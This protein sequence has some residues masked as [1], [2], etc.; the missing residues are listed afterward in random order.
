MIFYGVLFMREIHT[1]LITDTVCSLLLDAAYDIGRDV[2]FALDR[3]ASVEISPIGADVLSQLLENYAI[4]SSERIAV[5]QDTGMAVLFF[6]IGREVVICGG[7]FEDA[8]NEGVRRAY[9]NGHLRKS[10][11]SDPLF[12]RKNTLDNTPAVIHTRI[13]AGDHM[14]I[15]A[16]PKGFGSE[17]MSA[18][19]MLVPADGPE[20]V[21]RFIVDTVKKAGP[22][23]CPP[24]VVG[25]GIG[26][27]MEYAAIMAKKATARMIGLHN[28][29][30]R[31]ASL[32][33]E[34]LDEI[35]SLGIGPAGL[36]GR[37]T[38][39]AVNIDFSPTHIAGMPVAVN[40]CC[41]AARH[42]RAVL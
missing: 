25:V 20:G 24:V 13:V 11:V 4:A 17:N 42:S 40:I 34:V 41:H 31:Y 14:D 26:G 18:I 5:C 2:T 35:N 36:G 9:T 32:E 10:I 27:T 19:A 1:S 6:D 7:E 21:K 22:N 12:E 38:A 8:V 30:P 28:P 39:L 23:P 37:T 33:A 15:L 29:D 16:V 3:A